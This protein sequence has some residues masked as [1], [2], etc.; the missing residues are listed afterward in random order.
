MKRVIVS[1]YYNPL[2]GGHLDMIEAAANLGEYL[3]AVVNN[4][5]QAVMKK[6]R[7]F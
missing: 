6:A 3:I 1:G 7:L 5:I 2:H 4:D